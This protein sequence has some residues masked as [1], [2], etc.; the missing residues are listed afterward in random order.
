MNKKHG[1][2]LIELLV[3]ITIITLLVSILMPGLANAKLQAK[4]VVSANNMRQIGIALEM[5]AAD[6]RGYFPETSHGAVDPEAKSWVF[7]LSK[8]IADVD[9]VRICP[10]DPKRQERLENKVSSYVLNEYI[11]VGNTDPFGRMVGKSYRNKDRLKRPTET[12]TT[13][14]GANDLSA[15]ITS[16]HTH[17]RLWFQPAP[18]VPWD[19]LQ[20][21]IQVD[22]F[23]TGT[24]FLYA[25]SH[26]DM[27]DKGIIKEW[28][29]NYYDFAKPKD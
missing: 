29:D 17:S 22:R 16:D 24:L 18:N 26:V 20:K 21:D 25:D 19:T 10:A 11:A 6:N 23:K 14:I 12:I 2:T 27:V 13:F 5:Y 9:E 3:V 8:Y 4:R 28:T 7:T 15:S 1:F